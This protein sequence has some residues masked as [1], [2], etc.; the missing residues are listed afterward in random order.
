MDRKLLN[1]FTFHAMNSDFFFL[2]VCA[3]LLCS[4]ST[5]F[6]LWSYSLSWKK[7]NNRKIC[8]QYARMHWR[9]VILLF[10]SSSLFFFCCFGSK[11][12]N[13]LIR[14]FQFRT[15]RNFSYNSILFFS[16]NFRLNLEM[17]GRN[18]ECRKCTQLLQLQYSGTFE[19]LGMLHLHSSH[20]LRAHDNR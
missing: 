14:Q 20:Q 15:T 12:L 17:I 6:Y 13:K 2:L 19:Y 10:P 3:A 1:H 7:D 8:I 18:V 11:P 5:S 9:A 4:S 16:I